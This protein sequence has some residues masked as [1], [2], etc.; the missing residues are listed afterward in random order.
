M[1]FT[2]CRDDWRQKEPTITVNEDAAVQAWQSITGEDTLCLLLHCRGAHFSQER[3]C[4]EIYQCYVDLWLTMRLSPD[5]RRLCK[6]KRKDQWGGRCTTPGKSTGLWSTTLEKPHVWHYSHRNNLSV[7]SKPS[8]WAYI[9][10]IL[11]LIGPYFTKGTTCCID[12]NLKL[13]IETINS[14]EISLLRL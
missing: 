1:T 10:S 8:S 12:E 6:K 14:L 5:I 11:L 7:T 4:S 3:V 13:M 9:S 2:C